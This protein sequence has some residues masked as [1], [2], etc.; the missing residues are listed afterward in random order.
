MA[1]ILAALAVPVMLSP[2][3]G[4][5]A[6]ITGGVVRGA[7]LPTWIASSLAGFGITILVA[8]A[9]LDQQLDSVRSGHDQVL[10]G[11]VNRVLSARQGRPVFLFD[12]DPESTPGDI[13]QRLRLTWYDAPAV[14]T[15]GD[16]WRIKVRL[17]EPRGS[18]NPGSFDYERWLFAHQVGAIGYVRRDHRNRRIAGP[19]SPVSRMRVRLSQV[20]DKALGD[21]PAAG[22]LMALISGRRGQVQPEDKERFKLS[23]TAHLLAISGLHIGVA[24]G[25]G[26]LL[27]RLLW[28]LM[29]SIPRSGM[30]TYAIG[31]AWVAASAYALISGMSTA[32]RRAL[33]MIVVVLLAAAMRRSMPVFRGLALALISV[34]L[35]QPLAPLDGGFWLSFT[36]VAILTLRFQGRLRRLSW[37]AG[38]CQAQLSLS[39]AMLVPS[40]V[41]LGLVPVV[42]PVVNLLAVPLVA[43]IV[44][45]V[46]LGAALVGTVIQSFADLSLNLCAAL[47]SHMFDAIDWLLARGPDPL[48]AAAL[49]I[50]VVVV[51]GLASLLAILPIDVPGRRVAP[52]MLLPV[53]FW[54]GNALPENSFDL[55]V[56]DVGQGLSVVVRT[57]GRVLVYDGGPAWPGGD[58]G[59]TTVRPYLDWLGIR[60]IDTLVVSHGDMDHAG[61]AR[62][63]L[64]LVAGAVW[65]GPGTV[66]ADTRTQECRRGTRWSW[67]GVQ[68]EML[69]PDRGDTTQGNDAS[70]VLRVS[71][72]GGSAL[73][74]GDIES[75][76]ERRLLGA[77]DTLLTDLVIAPHHG[78][79]TSSHDELINATRPHW[80]V[81]AAGYR[82]RWG[83]P[84]P[85]VDQRWRAGGAR[86]L[87]SG[88]TGALTFRFRPSGARPELL[89]WRCAERRFWRPADC[90][91]PGY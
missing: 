55:T 51:A 15:A 44:I 56:L 70:C 5:L 71:S 1:G 26:A 86:T 84:R 78:S 36:A 41:L 2:F 46:S 79:A 50:P 8:G 35:L 12:P 9:A 80:V 29:A 28:H 49:P 48:R 47:L 13:P 81:F 16:L 74:T 10:E 54:K 62:S 68:F 33:A 52:L 37:F 87:V 7:R 91:A 76:G 39:V 58:S 88:E 18:S 25:A 20:V 21:A 63:L 67:D 23:G 38:L 30:A 69:H 4:L 53:L 65:A 64:P 24:A 45:P 11:R 61:G 75:A 73:L 32:T 14:P 72:P 59:M 57:R 89:G 85:E 22:V 60:A 66:L 90:I 3:I 82:N 43:V 83:F 17:R 42:G 27:G 6:L 34:L 19:V 31:G 77:S 40:M